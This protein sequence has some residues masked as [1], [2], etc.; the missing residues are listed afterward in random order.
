MKLIFFSDHFYSLSRAV[1][2]WLIILLRF[3]RLLFKADKRIKKQYLAVEEKHLFLKGHIVLKYKFDNAIWYE[4]KGYHKTFNR[5]GIIL[6]RNVVKSPVTL[7]VHGFFR[8][9]KEVIYFASKHDCCTESF[10]TSLDFR[11]LAELKMPYSQNLLKVH[12][13]SFSPSPIKFQ[14]RKVSLKKNNPK[15][16]YS[17]FNKKRIL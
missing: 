10:K 6:N 5:Q 16:N 9:N 17:H 15:I 12:P 1:R 14:F 2:F 8:K 11:H 7:I 13:K 3:I 4:I